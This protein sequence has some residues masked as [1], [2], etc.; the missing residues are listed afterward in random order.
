MFF[1]LQGLVDNAPTASPVCKATSRAVLLSSAGNDSA[2]TVVPVGAILPISVNIEAAVSAA[3]GAI[4]VLVGGAAAADAATAV[5]EVVFTPTAAEGEVKVTVT[6]GVSESG[7]IKVE[8]AQA[9]Q[10]IG[11]V[12]IPAAAV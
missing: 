7:E 4:Q 3:S 1:F 8:V 10:I 12:V 6:V 9:A 11:S 2:L 5:G